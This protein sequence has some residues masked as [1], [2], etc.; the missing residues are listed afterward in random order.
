MEYILFWVI[1]IT[2]V[3]TVERPER[4]VNNIDNLVRMEKAMGWE[5]LNNE[6]T[7]LYHQGDS[8]ALIGVE[9]D[10]EPPFSQFADLKKASEGTDGMFLCLFEPQ[11]YPLA[12]GSIARHRH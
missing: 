7:T 12:A 8:I 5:L 11:S 2:E 1:M 4:Q 9:N 10:G 3:T 6:H